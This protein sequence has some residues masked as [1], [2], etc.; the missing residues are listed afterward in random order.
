MCSPGQVDRVDL[1]RRALSLGLVERG[2]PGGV[3]ASD[4][5]R[6]DLL[7][8]PVRGSELRAAHHVEVQVRCQAVAGVADQRQYVTPLDP[9]THRA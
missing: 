7:G 6:V 9:V 8:Q 1:E 2:R 5:E 3:T 4:L